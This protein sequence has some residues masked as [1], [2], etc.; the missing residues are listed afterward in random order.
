MGR[1]L[2]LGTL[3]GV[4]LESSWGILGR[5]GGRLG[6]LVHSKKHDASAHIMEVRRRLLEADSIRILGTQIDLVHSKKQES[7]A[8]AAPHGPWKQADTCRPRRDGFLAMK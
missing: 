1:F 3:L 5:L 2:P 8:H 7:S 4:L 6:R